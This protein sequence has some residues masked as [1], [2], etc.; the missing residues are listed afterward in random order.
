M[1]KVTHLKIS[2]LYFN[3]VKKIHQV[4]CYNIKYNY[5]D[6]I[7]KIT[8]FNDNKYVCKGLN[9][10][11]KLNFGEQTRLSFMEE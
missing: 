3:T 11:Y 6:N 2:N 4:F 1:V 7:F 9:L 10:P 8:I 5:I